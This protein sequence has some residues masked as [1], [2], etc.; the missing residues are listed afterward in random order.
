MEEEFVIDRPPV[1]TR[2]ETAEL[3]VIQ[4]IESKS[5]ME[6]AAVLR[7]L[8]RIGLTK[9]DVFDPKDLLRLARRARFVE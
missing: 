8:I 3:E 6:R 1:S 4:L 2:L 7:G 5:G 9:I